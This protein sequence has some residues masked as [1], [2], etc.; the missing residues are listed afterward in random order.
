MDWQEILKKLDEQIDHIHKLI[1]HQEG[2]E[3]ILKLEQALDVAIRL[4]E[5]QF[6]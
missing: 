6:G 3:N 1:I 4:R 5:R 2:P